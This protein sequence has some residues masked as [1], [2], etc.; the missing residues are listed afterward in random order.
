MKRVLAVTLAILCGVAF[1]ESFAKKP[2][3]AMPENHEQFEDKM[4]RNPNQA[5]LD[6]L[7]R[8]ME[9][10]DSLR[11]EL[12][13]LEALLE[14]QR[15]RTRGPLPSYKEMEDL[16]LPCQEEVKSTD[17]YYGA[18]AVSDGKPNQSIAVQDAMQKAQFEL[19][20]LV[21]ENTEIEN[22]EVV[23]RSI[24]RDM[25]GNFIAYVA[26]RMPKNK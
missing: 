6:S 17:D 2:Q 10:Q 16:E 21:G 3:K 22:V 20:K 1:S 9:R 8:E 5:K 4:H 14:E 25:H 26:I 23:C 13:K 12:E 11:T 24:M 15:P 19:A 7:R 18:W